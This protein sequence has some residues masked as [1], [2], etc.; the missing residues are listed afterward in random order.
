ME[1]VSFE[2][3]ESEDL[4]IDPSTGKFPLVVRNKLKSVK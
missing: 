4:M 1:N 3:E 2:I